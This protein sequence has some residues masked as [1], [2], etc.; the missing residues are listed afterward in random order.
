VNFSNLFL[1]L[2]KQAYSSM[3]AAQEAGASTLNSGLFIQVVINLL[4]IV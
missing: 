3:T 2:D 1:S 4:I